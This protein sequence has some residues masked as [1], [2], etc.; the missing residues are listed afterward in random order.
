[1]NNNP[2]LASYIRGNLS[3]VDATTTDKKELAPKETSPLLQHFSVYMG[4]KSQS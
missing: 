4:A 1:M 2:P 3:V